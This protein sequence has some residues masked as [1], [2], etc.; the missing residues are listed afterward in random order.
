MA[1]KMLV[2]DKDTVLLIPAFEIN[3]VPQ[4]ALPSTAAAVPI[5]DPTSALLNYFIGITNPD[6]VGASWGGNITCSIIDDCNLA[7]AASA[8]SDVRTLCSIGQSQELTFYNFDGTMNFLRDIDPQDGT[9]EFNLPTNLLGGPDIPY[10][11]AHRIGYKHDVAAAIGQ[12]WHYY[13]FWTDHPIPAASDGDNLALGETFV[14]K[15]L[16]NFKHE[17]TV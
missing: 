4:M 17:L 11:I 14:P 6:D 7:L 16:I 1:Q 8:T 2:G 15:G 10:V 3:G 9:S 13:Y 5:D 12:E